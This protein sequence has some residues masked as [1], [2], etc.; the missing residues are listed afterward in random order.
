MDELDGAMGFNDQDRPAWK[1]WD[2]EEVG[3]DVLLE[4]MF[5]A[6]PGLS[7]AWR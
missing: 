5:K 4:Q 6:G 2:R 3:L 7:F 1:N